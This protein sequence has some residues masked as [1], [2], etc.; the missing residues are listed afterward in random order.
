[1]SY[2]GVMGMD[3][4]YDEALRIAK[5]VEEG[6]R[7]TV[8]TNAVAERFNLVKA[9]DATLDSMRRTLDEKRRRVAA[10]QK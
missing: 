7:V 4:K 2:T 10:L 8:V 5:R 1:M 9:A 3:L 6:P